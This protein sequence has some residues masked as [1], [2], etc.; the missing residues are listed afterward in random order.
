MI[1]AIFTYSDAIVAL[2]DWAGFTGSPSP[3]MLRKVK[4]SIENSYRALTFKRNWSYYEYRG[5]INTNPLYN[6][7]TIAYTN[8]TRTVTLTGGTLPS[9]T[10]LCILRVGPVDYPVVNGSANIGAG[11][12][13]LSVN[14]NPTV[15]L[16]AGT[17]YTLYQD[18]YPLPVNFK[19]MGTL[20]DCNRSRV[21]QYIAPNEFVA[22]RQIFQPPAIP[23]RYTLRGDPS[24]LGIEA[25]SFYPAPDQFYQ[26]EYMGIRQPRPFTQTIPYS[27]GTISTSGL[28]VTGTGT[29]FTSNMVG[30]ILRISNSGSLPT[31]T[32]GSNPYLVQRVITSYTSA[33]VIGIDQALSAEVSG[34]GFEISDP[35]D[36]ESFGMYTMFLRLCEVEL[37]QLMNRDDVPR[38]RSQYQIAEREALESDQKSRDDK[39]S[40]TRPYQRV[41]DYTPLTDANN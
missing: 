12:F 35:I 14:N 32:V 20:R 37:G 28:V 8:S 3:E 16:V 9:N 7:G 24:Y 30:C 22:S 17:A 29:T 38:L 18:T 4:R 31:G 33:T 36:M 21:L 25:I 19:N 6:T 2:S 41:A 26:Y 1:P 5:R 27:T 40:G 39:P 15:D 11:T 23:Y 10:N 34:A 13:Q